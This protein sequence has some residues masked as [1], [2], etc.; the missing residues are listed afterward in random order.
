MLEW[1]R[2]I[3]NMDPIKD[4]TVSF[5]KN[6][7][8]TESAREDLFHEAVKKVAEERVKVL[9]KRGLIDLVYGEGTV[10]DTLRAQ[11]AMGEMSL[12]DISKFMPL[13]VDHNGRRYANLTIYDNKENWHPRIPAVSVDMV[14]EALAK[15]YVNVNY[16]AQETEKEE[17]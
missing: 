8:F 3:F 15:H 9:A 7:D 12:E 14:T 11:E 2:E 4:Q 1:T 6:L 17:K 10:S 5:S 16:N 13:A